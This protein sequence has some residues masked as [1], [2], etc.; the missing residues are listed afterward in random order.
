M[1]QGLPNARHYMWAEQ[2]LPPSATPSTTLGRILSGSC[3]SGTIPALTRDCL[4]NT[5]S[6]AS[7]R[8]HK[9]LLERERHLT[10]PRTSSVPC[11]ARKLQSSS[12]VIKVDIFYGNVTSFYRAKSKKTALVDHSFPFVPCGTCQRAGELWVSSEWASWLPQLLPHS[13]QA[14]P[15]GRSADSKLYWLILPLRIF[16]TGFPSAPTYFSEHSHLY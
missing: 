4:T 16:Q 12:S 7:E 9:V 15:Q 3:P 6:W 11:T 2:E 8:Q 13:L 5:K 1:E 10:P 14:A